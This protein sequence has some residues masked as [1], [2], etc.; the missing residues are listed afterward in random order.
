MSATKG[1]NSEE[2]DFA[3]WRGPKKD[4]SARRPGESHTQYMARMSERNSRIGKLARKPSTVRSVRFDS[5]D[6]LWWR[7]ANDG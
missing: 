5:F 3:H 4:D 2:D 7:L 1:W 6:E